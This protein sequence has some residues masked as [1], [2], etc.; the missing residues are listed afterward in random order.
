M[1]RRPDPGRKNE[2]K[3]RGRDEVREIRVWWWVGWD[4]RCRVQR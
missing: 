1:G 3:E 4:G 2:D